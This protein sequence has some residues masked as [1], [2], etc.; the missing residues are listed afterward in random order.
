MNSRRSGSVS[1][2]KWVVNASPLILLANID[3]L[4]LD[5]GKKPRNLVSLYWQ[6]R[7]LWWLT[8]PGFYAKM[9][10]KT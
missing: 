3:R 5:S 4:P 2:R 7:F 9:I 10:R 6:T 8:K 1:E